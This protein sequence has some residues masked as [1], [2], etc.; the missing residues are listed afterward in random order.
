MAMSRRARIDFANALPTQHSPPLTLALITPF[1]LFLASTHLKHPKNTIM[2][3]EKDWKTLLDY[4]IHSG[5]GE[6]ISRYRLHKYLQENF[7]CDMSTQECRQAFKEALE[8][9]KKEGYVE[10][11]QGFFWFSK[12]GKKFYEETYDVTEEGE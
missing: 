4:G 9:R 3:S 11:G 2:A 8:A 1:R 10:Q 12:A 5:K 6:K 7:E